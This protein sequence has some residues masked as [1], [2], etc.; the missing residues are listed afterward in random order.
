MSK[1]TCTQDDARDL[2][3]A[4]ERFH[5]HCDAKNEQSARFWARL[6]K[7]A[8]VATGITLTSELVLSSYLY[9]EW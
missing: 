9:G 1:P 7:E 8:Q 2:A 5:A 4:Y 3:V 6:L